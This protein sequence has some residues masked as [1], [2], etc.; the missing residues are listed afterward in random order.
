[1]LNRLQAALISLMASLIIL[2]GLQPVQACV[3]GLAWGM[4]LDQ[5]HA[6]L[7]EIHQANT[8]HPERFFARNV[9]LDRLPVSQVTFDL[10]PDAGLQSLA[11]EFAIDDMTEVLAGLRAR[12]G[13]PLSTSSMDLKQNEQIWVWNTGEDLITAVKHDGTTHQKFVIAYRPSRLRPETL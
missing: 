10:T 5:V 9:M 3:E 1:M 8:T 7:G 2:W 12:H 4:P 11:Y 13:S 6:H